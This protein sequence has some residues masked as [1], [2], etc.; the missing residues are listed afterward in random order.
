VKILDDPQWAEVSL[1]EFAASEGY[2]EE[3]LE[4]YLVPMS[5][6]VWSTE[7]G[8][9]LDFPAATLVR[10]FQNHGFLG[11]DT[12]HQWRTVVGGSRNYRDR[13]IAP[14]ADRIRCGRAAAKVARVGTTAMVADASGHAESFDAV[15]FA[16]HADEA[17]GLLAEPTPAE[18][19]L[20]GKF[21]YQENIA[22][23]HT[24]ASVMPRTNRAWSSWN[25]RI[26]RRGG[27]LLPSTV[28][29][30]NSLQKVSDRRDYFISIGDPGAV[31]P[32]AVLKTVVY[33]HPVFT[34]DTARA[35]RDLPLLNAGGP[36]YYCGSYFRN[37][38]H[39]D[40]LNSAIDLS[41]VLLEE[42]SR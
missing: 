27:E 6:A 33:T 26:E 35:Q 9:M 4:R 5:S 18:D 40:A 32:G 1:A 42:V 7:P 24:D 15:I 38:F 14:Y 28:Y 13:L 19:A 37:G 29:Y 17:L 22:T 16:C 3:F 25:Y 31:D 34:V 12:Q 36:L 30:M 23:L 39:E 21:R 10:F 11:L 8:R 2:S 20:L 41:K